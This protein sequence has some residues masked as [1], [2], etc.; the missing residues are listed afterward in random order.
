M[1]ATLK[2]VTMAI[3]SAEGVTGDIAYGSQW[4]Y[5]K[6]E[7]TAKRVVEAAKGDYDVAIA[8]LEAAKR[9]FY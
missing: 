2:D 1:T 3:A 6:C 7:A 4:T 5:N 8:V 9:V